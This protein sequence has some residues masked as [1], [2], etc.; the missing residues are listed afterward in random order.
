TNPGVSPASAGRHGAWRLP[1]ETETSARG[2]FA[3]RPTGATRPAALARW[4]TDPRNRMDDGE[5]IRAP[6]M[7]TKLFLSYSKGDPEWRDLFVLHLNSLSAVAQDLWV[8]IASIDD[9]AEWERQIVSALPDSRCALLLITPNYL[10]V[11][12]YARQELSLLAREQEKGL[13]LLPVLVE[14]CT[15]KDDETLSRLQFVRWSSDTVCVGAGSTAREDLRALS[16]AG[17]KFAIDRAV[18]EV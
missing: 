8:D 12:H 1:G 6:A 10:Q 11:Q 2:G 15:W 5:T 17:D 14:P 3:S 13:K 7:R 4:P 16:E 9:G 18:I